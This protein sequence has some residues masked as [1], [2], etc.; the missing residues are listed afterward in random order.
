MFCFC[1]RCG[2]RTDERNGEKW[3]ERKKQRVEQPRTSPGHVI[4]KMATAAA[5]PVLKTQN[6]EWMLTFVL[7]I[8]IVCQTLRPEGV[9]KFYI[10]TETLEMTVFVRVIYL[11][12]TAQTWTRPSCLV[13]NTPGTTYH[14]DKTVIWLLGFNQNTRGVPGIHRHV[15]WRQV[16]GK[17][18]DLVWLGSVHYPLG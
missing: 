17:V 16:L 15:H 10:P 13:R 6:Y 8:R 2:L 14:H 5:S 3:S 1:Y 12:Q 11:V 9:Q 7:M 18:V 4:T